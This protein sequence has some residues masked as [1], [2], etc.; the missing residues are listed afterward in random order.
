[1]IREELARI[2]QELD[3]ARAQLATIPE[4]H[5]AARRAPE[6]EADQALGLLDDIRRVAHD[7]AARAR[8]LPLMQRLGLRIGLRFVDAAKK[9]RR[10]RRLGW[11]P[12]GL[13]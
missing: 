7:P 3:S 10:V 5:L 2:E 6:E 4:G 9:T 11:R 12:V 8:V 1:M 13:R